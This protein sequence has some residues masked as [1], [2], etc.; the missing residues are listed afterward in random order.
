[1]TFKLFSKRFVYIV[2]ILM[3]FVVG[4]NIYLDEFGLFGNVKGRELRVTNHERLTKY[5]YSYNYIPSNF[6]G[7]L[8][9]PSFSNIMLDTKKIDTYKVY[10]L[11]MSGTKADILEKAVNNVI[12]KGSLKMLIICIDEYIVTGSSNAEFKVLDKLYSSSL[13]SLFNIQYYLRKFFPSKELAGDYWGEFGFLNN[14]HRHQTI[15]STQRID[16]SIKEFKG[17]KLKINESLF[18]SLERLIK[19]AKDNKVKILAYYHPKP[20]RKFDFLNRVNYF[21]NYKIR[22]DNFLKNR[23]SEIIDFN[24]DDYLHITN[25]D[26]SFYDGAHLSKFGADKIIKALNKSLVKLAKKDN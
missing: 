18:Q 17:K 23:V 3:T 6:D 14:E 25:D 8:T 10:N 22:M 2:L 1:M 11:S 12:E 7:V 21:D 4:F 20:K 9:G 15:S 19:K 24:T 26:N 16:K 5:L 13:G